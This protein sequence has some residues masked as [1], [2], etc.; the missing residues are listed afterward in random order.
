MPATREQVLEALFAKLSTAYA[1]SAATRRNASPET[2]A[3]AGGSALALVVHHEDYHRPSPS[4]PPRRTLTALAIVYVNVGTDPNAVPDAVLNPI[5][6]AIDAALKA[7]NPTTGL[8]TLGGLVY[9][10]LSR[11]RGDPGPGRQA[12][13]GPRRHADQARSALTPRPPVSPR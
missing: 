9:R 7:D 11:G 5:K 12:R 6:D 8:C 10:R 13:P 4:A 3:P 1:F 2:L